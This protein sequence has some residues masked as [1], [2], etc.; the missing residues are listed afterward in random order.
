M[1]LVA[2][3]LAEPN[4]AFN[5]F[6]FRKGGS[7]A[8]GS[9]ST[10]SY[11]GNNKE[12]LGWIVAR[13]LFLL[14]GWSSFAETTYDSGAASI[15]F[16]PRSEIRELKQLWEK[17]GDTDKAAYYDRLDEVGFDLGMPHHRFDLGAS[18]DDTLARFGLQSNFEE[19]SDLWY[20]QDGQES[21][22]SLAITIVKK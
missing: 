6:H 8:G 17:P 5:P 10:F 11:N 22:D 15:A 21:T 20:G 2:S 19:A 4:L 9:N 12:L 3:T 13:V 18:Q 1:R 7:G 16:A 14:L